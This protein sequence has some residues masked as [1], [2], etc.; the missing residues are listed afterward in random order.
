MTIAGSWEPLSLDLPICMPLWVQELYARYQSLLTVLYVCPFV[1]VCVDPSSHS[2][3]CESPGPAQIPTSF[4]WAFVTQ[5]P[6]QYSCEF[7][8]S[9]NIPHPPSSSDL[10]ACEISEWSGAPFKFNW[11]TTVDILKMIHWYSCA[12]F[13]H[14]SQNVKLFLLQNKLPQS[15]FK[16]IMSYKKYY[17]VHVVFMF[18]TLHCVVVRSLLELVQFCLRFSGPSCSTLRLVPDT[19]SEISFSSTCS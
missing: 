18:R 2:G 19:I 10:Y 15:L 16:V 5:H 9:S 13:K 14:I 7:F 17:Y 6:S 1:S 11:T 8:L 4:P 12:M 3:S